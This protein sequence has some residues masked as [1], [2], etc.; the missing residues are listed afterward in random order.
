MGFRTFGLW[1]L[2]LVLGVTSI[3]STAEAQVADQPQ[4][5][6]AYHDLAAI[7]INPL[8]LVNFA[9]FSYRYRL[10]ESDSDA[11]KQNFVGLGLATGLS[12]AWGRIGLMAEVQPLT[13]LRLYA[14]YE[15]VGYYGSFDLFASFPT[16]SANYSDTAIDDRSDMPGT[17]NYATSGS[18]LT[19]GATLQLKVGPIAVRSLFRSYYSNFDLR[20]GDRV[21][22]DQI[23][24]MLMPDEGWVVVNDLDVLAVFQAAGYRFAAGPRYTYS[25]AFY[26]ESHFLPGEDASLAPSNNIHRLGVLLAWTLRDNP[27]GRFDRPTLV[28]V[29]QWH[30]KHRWRT[31][32]D[33]STGL[34]Y[35]ALAFTFQ[36]D[37]LAD[38]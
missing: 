16:A 33:V 19:L 4:H 34:P 17:E 20:T 8:G 14:Q 18:L 28:L 24:D 30:L 2:G 6:I 3:T 13:I 15:V 35:L 38:H 23:L 7:R 27:G 22:Y 26:D 37:L 5:S 12:P 1:G 31:G 36:G 32:E 11:F 29:A 21:Y 25:H 9:R 10:F